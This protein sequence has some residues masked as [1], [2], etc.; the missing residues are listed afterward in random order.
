MMSTALET[1]T[2]QKIEE[3]TMSAWPALQT[4]Y[5]DGWI[6]RF[7]N[8]YTRRANSVSTLYPGTGDMREK[9]AYC[10]SLY[11]LYGI[12]PAFKHTPASPVGLEEV[13]SDAGYE[14]EAPSLVMFLPD[15]APVPDPEYPAVQIE[16]TISPGWIADYLAL[17]GT[18]PVHVPTMTQML[19]STRFPQAFVRLGEPGKPGEPS[20]PAAVGMAAVNYGYVCFND[21]VVS[22]AMRGKGIGTQLMRHLIAWARGEGAQ[23]GYLQVL[24]DN[25]PA[26][27]LYTGL[28][29][30]ELYPYW[31]RIKAGH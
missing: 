16:A 10:E 17:S 27:K 23:Y 14:V 4:A 12:R 29:F 31:Y 19:T 30:R 20:A 6:L 5:C 28:G 18:N 21:I 13:L 3:L 22:A 2:P 9:I 15:T 26:L 8:G 11:R 25:A 1:A 7:A 24:G